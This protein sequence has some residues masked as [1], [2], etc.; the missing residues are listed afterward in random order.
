ML[1]SSAASSQA[2]RAP[3]PL[4]GLTQRG[5]VPPYSH[6]SQGQV[7]QLLL[8]S[9]GMDP[10][11]LTCRG[12]FAREATRCV[13]AFSHVASLLSSST[14]VLGTKLQER[15]RAGFSGPVLLSLVTWL[16]TC[17]TNRFISAQEKQ[18]HSVYWNT[19]GHQEILARLQLLGRFFLLHPEPSFSSSATPSKHSPG[20]WPRQYSGSS[21]ISASC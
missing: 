12:D 7:P 1:F 18:C 5:R 10:G 8:H 3:L 9:Q 20:N 13:V 17:S 14:R 2:A 16:V 6:R 4:P 11:S 15:P 21:F 19:G